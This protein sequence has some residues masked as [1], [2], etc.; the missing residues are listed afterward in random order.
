MPY[1]KF[2]CKEM[3][4]V[5]IMPLF[6]RNG[7]NGYAPRLRV[8]LNWGAPAGGLPSAPTATR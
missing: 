1:C 8:E 7:K 4:N 6:F 3:Y 5:V 2:F